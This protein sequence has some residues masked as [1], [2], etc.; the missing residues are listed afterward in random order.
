MLKPFSL[1]ISELKLNIFLGGEEKSQG[2]SP[3]DTG[4]DTNGAKLNWVFS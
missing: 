2:T 4:G 1:Y 3:S